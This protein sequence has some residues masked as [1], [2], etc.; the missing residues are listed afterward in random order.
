L[1]QEIRDV[2]IDWSIKETT[3]VPNRKDFMKRQ[4]V[5]KCF[6]E[7]PKHFL[8][9]SQVRCIGFNHIFEL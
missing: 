5:V 8:Q 4:I 9:V 6:E 7:H 3:I 2:V 1:P